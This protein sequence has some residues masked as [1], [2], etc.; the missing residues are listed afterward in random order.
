MKFKKIEKLIKNRKSIFIYTD[1]Q[2]QWL[3]DGCSAYLVSDM[4][5]LEPE[6][7]LKLFD[8]SDDKILSFNC[9]KTSLPEKLN[10]SDTDTSEN[11]VER[12]TYHI[13]INGGVYEP[14]LTS[15][16]YSSI[17]ITSSRSR[18][19]LTTLC[20]SS[21]GQRTARCILRRKAASFLSVCS[22]LHICRQHRLKSGRIIC[23]Q[24]PMY[25]IST[26]RRKTKMLLINILGGL[27]VELGLA[28]E[29]V[30]LVK[31]LDMILFGW[32]R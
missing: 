5:S 24:R 26:E 2:N 1:G 23:L 8:I 9:V 27:L 16:G 32:V 17:L 10:F 20:Y 30:E 28:D 29:F 22:F 3:G 12:E 4:P 7:L 6:E 11:L 14:I 15:E 19:T 18:V 13:C 31:V 21:V 25:T